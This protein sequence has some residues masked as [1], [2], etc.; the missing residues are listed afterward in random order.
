MTNIIDISTYEPTSEDKIFIDNNIWMYLFFPYNSG[1]ENSDLYGTFFGKLLKSKCR[2][3]TSSIILSEFFNS[4]AKSHFV[5]K[6]SNEKSQKIPY[7]K[8]VYK[9]YKRD[10]RNTPEFIE[11]S[12]AI[13]NILFDE[14]LSYSLK[15]DDMFSSINMN[16]ILSSDDCFDFNDKYIV[17]LC[18]YHDFKILTNDKDFLNFKT[19][20]KIITKHI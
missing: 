3:Y 7:D 4:Y 6:Q 19:N 2:I 18:E 13:R 17:A 16:T 1:N 9:N 8:R 11:I 14:I 12:K 20:V 5:A 15:V 10:F